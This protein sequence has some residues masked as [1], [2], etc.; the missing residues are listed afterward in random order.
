M[1]DWLD[2]H[3]PDK[4]ATYD[5]LR[6]H[7]IGEEVLEDLIKKMHDRCQAVIDANGEHIPY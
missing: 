6:R 5:Q 3:Y 2:L 7:V 1:N 4:K